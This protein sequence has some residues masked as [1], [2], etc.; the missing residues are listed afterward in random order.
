MEINLECHL[1]RYDTVR[2]VGRSNLADV[3]RARA[4]NNYAD[5]E[6]IKNKNI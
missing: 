1:I 6:Q 4:V 5:H 3:F 2:N